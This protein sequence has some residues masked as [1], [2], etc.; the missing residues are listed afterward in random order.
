MDTQVTTCY[1]FLRLPSIKQKTMLLHSK[2][3][4]GYYVVKALYYIVLLLKVTIYSVVKGYNVCILTT[5]GI[6]KIRS[7]KL[8]AFSKYTALTKVRKNIVHGDQGYYRL[9][10]F[11]V[12]MHSTRNHVTTWYS[13]EWLLCIQG[14]SYMLMLWNVTMNSYYK[15][16]AK[17]PA[18]KRHQLSRPM[19]IVG[20]KQIWRGCVIYL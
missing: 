16:Y 2:V 8:T 12:T 15:R 10:L 19:Q 18:Y 4:S 14:C 20:P 3:F 7:H 9:L 11:E 17:N 13:C 1:C 6:P 5:N